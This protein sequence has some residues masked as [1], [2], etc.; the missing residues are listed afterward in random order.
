MFVT[1]VNPWQRRDDGRPTLIM[2]ECTEETLGESLG[3]AIAIVAEE[4]KVPPDVREAKMPEIIE[5]MHEVTDA[6]TL[7]IV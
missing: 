1:V 3:R 4:F 5:S 2:V 7:P 6:T